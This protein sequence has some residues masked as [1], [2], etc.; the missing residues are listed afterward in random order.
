[1]STHDEIHV[2]VQHL[3][4]YLHTHPFACDTCE[5]IERWWLATDPPLQLQQLQQALDWMVAHALVDRLPAADG[6]IRYRRASLDKTAE[7]VLLS[8]AYTAESDP[9]R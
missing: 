6:R 4:R 7:N 2:V 9:P 8:L 3:A 5:G 1:M